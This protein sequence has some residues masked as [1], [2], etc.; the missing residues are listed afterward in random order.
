[1]T[2]LCWPSAEKQSWCVTHVPLTLSL[3]VS[4][5]PM[6]GPSLA[7]D[8]LRWLKALCPFPCCWA[9]FRKDIRARARWYG[10]AAALRKLESWRGSPGLGQGCQASDTGESRE[11]DRSPVIRNVVQGQRQL[12][13]CHAAALGLSG[14][15]LSW[16]CSGLRA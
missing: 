1:M 2:C 10:K 3:L 5:V 6:L 14:M 11:Q 12:S 8:S 9:R 16:I 15:T 13:T 7:K 4:P